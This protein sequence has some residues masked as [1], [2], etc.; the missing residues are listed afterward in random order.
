M[1]KI[2]NK[3]QLL[4]WALI[5][6]GVAFAA[7]LVLMEP[8]EECLQQAERVGELAHLINHSRGQEELAAYRSTQPDVVRLIVL[9]PHHG[10]GWWRT[11]TFDLCIERQ[12]EGTDST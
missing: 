2:I 6:T 1:I 3:E 7:A 9:S 11:H 12:I 10:A 4:G 5:L 8:V